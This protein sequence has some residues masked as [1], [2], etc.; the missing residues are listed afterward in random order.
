MRPNQA[1]HHLHAAPS[2]KYVQY[3]RRTTCS[4]DATLTN[5]RWEKELKVESEKLKAKEASRSDSTVLHFTLYTLHSSCLRFPDY[6]PAP[7][8]A[9][10]AAPASRD[11]DI[12]PKPLMVVRRNFGKFESRRISGKVGLETVRVD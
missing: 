10:P 12:I 7:H 2:V 3:F 4:V 11:D 8:R 9:T 6:D 1:H 5:A